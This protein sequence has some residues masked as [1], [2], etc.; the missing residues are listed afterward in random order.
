[1][2]KSY[3]KV[4][5]YNQVKLLISSKK[6]YIKQV[7]IGHFLWSSN[8]FHF[9]IRLYTSLLIDYKILVKFIGLRHI[10]RSNRKK[11]SLDVRK[12]TDTV[13]YFVLSD[14]KFVI[15]ANYTQKKIASKP[16]RIGK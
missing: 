4:I 3:T 8:L 11:P 7:F 13:I 10:L 5:D 15:S 6:S 14:F 1:M 2:V 12:I 16:T 9:L